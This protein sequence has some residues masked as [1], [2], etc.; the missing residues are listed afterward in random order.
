MENQKF[1]LDKKS[2]SGLYFDSLD[3]SKKRIIDL[4]N[5]VINHS[6][7]SHKIIENDYRNIDVSVVGLK[8]GKETILY[9]AVAPKEVES[10]MEQ[11]YEVYK[12]YNLANISDPFIKSSIMHLL[13]VR[14]HPFR[15]G[16]GRTARLIHNL[17]FTDCVNKHYGTNLN[18]SP[19]N[20][21]ENININKITYATDLDRIMFVLSDEENQGINIFLDHILNNYDERLYYIKNSGVRISE[22]SK[23]LVH[24]LP[25]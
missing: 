6:N 4:H 18:I 1:V 19:L 11:F 3:I 12:N 20:I 8:D 13:F 21:S 15:D 14:V 24:I 10:Y 9:N 22:K 17:K 5:F 25:R 16:N 2:E 7:S 23:K